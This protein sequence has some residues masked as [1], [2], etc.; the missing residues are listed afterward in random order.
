MGIEEE[1]RGREGK[2]KGKEKR[3]EGRVLW[4]QDSEE[5][6]CWAMCRVSQYR[7]KSRVAESGT[8][9][10]NRGG[11]ARPGDTA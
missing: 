11:T 5:R 3:Q 1:R 2:H 9:V 7:N 8:N 6:K 4:G 10:Q